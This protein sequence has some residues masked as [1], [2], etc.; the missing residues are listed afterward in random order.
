MIKKI[1][2]S[3]IDRTNLSKF[4]TVENKNKDKFDYAGIVVQKPWGYEYLMYENEFV[5]IWILHL[6]KGQEN[7][8]HCHPKKKTSMI[9]LSGKIRATT[10]NDWFELDRLDGLIYENGLFHTQKALSDDVFLM[11]IE[12][13]PDK[14]DLVRLKD[15]Y[16]REGKAYEGSNQHS[17][18]LKKF[19]YVYFKQQDLKRKI[20]KRFKKIHISLKT[21][22]T[23]F[24]E[25]EVEINDYLQSKFVYSIIEDKVIDPDYKALFWPGAIFHQ[26]HIKN[27]KNL[28]LKNSCILLTISEN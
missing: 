23:N 3:E 17:K 11:E 1:Y 9:V 25:Q 13:P 22:S 8:L 12:T 14:S 27:K 10:L 5:A 18:D 28:K 24:L 16:G 15:T 26:D 19:D 4:K 21:C 2:T 6:K 7:S 20:K